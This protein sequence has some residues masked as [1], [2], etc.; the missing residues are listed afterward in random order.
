[1]NYEVDSAMLPNFFVIGATRAGTTSLFQYLR[2]HPDIFLPKIKEIWGFNVDDRHSDLQRYYAK[3][4]KDRREELMV[5][6]ITPIYLT[7]GLLYHSYGSKAYLSETDS[8]IRRIAH[9]CPEARIIV[10]LRSPMSRLRSQYQKNYF[11]GKA[12]VAETLEDHARAML[13]GLCQPQ[14]DYIMANHY[15]D[16]LSEVYDVFDSS[17]VQL[18]I[19]EEWGGDPNTAVEQ[20]INFLGI[21]G[22]VSIDTSR[23]YNGAQKYRTKGNS[24]SKLISNLRPNKSHN[25]NPFSLSADTEAAM[26]EKFKDDIS[27]VEERLNRPVPSWRP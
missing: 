20:M 11:Q 24:I 18:L 12:G 25:K 9:A 17:Q 26:V 27:Y 21:D 15:A 2:Q 23:Q 22:N 3:I 7:R 16:H 1:M 13:E 14:N 19:I 4:M 6:D 10:T 8:S 5:G